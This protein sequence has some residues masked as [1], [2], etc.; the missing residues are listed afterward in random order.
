MFPCM[1]FDQVTINYDTAEYF[2]FRLFDR[3]GQSL[4]YR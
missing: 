2:S 3:E 1:A 4:I